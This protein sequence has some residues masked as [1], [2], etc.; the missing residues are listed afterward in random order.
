MASPREIQRVDVVLTAGCNLRCGYCYQ[1]DKKARSMDWETLRASA[2]LLLGSRQ[3]EVRMLFIGG[4]PLLEFPLIRQAVA[5]IEAARPPH[6]TVR[7]QVVTNGTLLREEQVLFLIEHDFEVQLSFDGVP[8]AQDLRGRG[9]F[10]VLD[11]LLDRLRADEPHFFATKVSV[12]LTLLPATIPFLADSVEYFLAKGVPQIAVSPALTHQPAWRDELMAEL[13]VQFSRI[14]DAS[15][16]HYHRTGDVPFKLFRREHGESGQRP[17]GIG[18]CGVGRGETPAVDV[19]GQVHG[20]VMFVDSYQKFPT[21]FL[22]T[23]LEAMRMGRL[24][25]ARLPRRM[26]AYP[27]A[28]EAARIFDDKQDKYSSY[29]RCGECRFLAVCGVCP[30]SIGHQPGNDDPRRI[31]DF[32]CAYNLVSLAHR[33]RFPIR[34]TASERL[35][36]E[37]MMPEELGALLGLAGPEPS[38]RAPKGRARAGRRA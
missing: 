15:L 7:Y 35:A 1:N 17:E 21:K 3:P 2:D 34:P 25:D 28:A 4:E 8:A 10:A 14:F 36:G 38:A 22:R 6:Q 12:A 13:D 9:T 18:M 19:D 20:C 32:Q 29:G 30:V 5:Y 11:R 27:A 26:A 24:G 16:A 37:A 33:E 31:P 23:R